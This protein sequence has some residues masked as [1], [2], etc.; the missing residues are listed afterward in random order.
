MILPSWFCCAQSCVGATRAARRAEHHRTLK[1]VLMATLD[2]IHRER[3]KGLFPIFRNKPSKQSNLQL[4]AEL[5]ADL[6]VARI[7][8][9]GGL[10]KIRSGQERAGQRIG[11]E[12]LVVRPAARGGEDEVRSVED[13]KG[14]RIELQTDS[15]G[16]LEVFRQSHIRRPVAWANEGVAT[17]IA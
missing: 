15:F 4:E 11:V 3:E 5:H 6:H 14:S 1:R 12:V 2:K 16:D 8:S 17:Q 13:V 7:E 9:S 10:A